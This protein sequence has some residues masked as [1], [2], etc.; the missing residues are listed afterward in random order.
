MSYRNTG[1]I[2]YCIAITGREGADGEAEFSEAW[3][4]QRLRCTPLSRFTL[5]LG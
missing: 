2:G 4:R 3:H 5:A 1:N